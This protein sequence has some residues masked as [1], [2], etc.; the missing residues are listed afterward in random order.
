MGCAA[1]LSGLHRGL[2][3]CLCL[4]DPRQSHRNVSEDGGSQSLCCFYS[5]H[6]LGS[7]LRSLEGAWPLWTRRGTKGAC[8]SEGHPDPLAHQVLVWRSSGVQSRLTW[9][10]VPIRPVIP[11]RMP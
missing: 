3:Y 11:E 4:S 2:F 1:W 7:Q 9:G 6:V 8:T 10:Q 5:A